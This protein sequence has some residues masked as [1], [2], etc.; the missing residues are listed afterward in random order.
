MGES[1]HNSHH[2]DPTNAR[3]GVLRG[4]WVWLDFSLNRVAALSDPD[5]SFRV[6]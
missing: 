4:I 2:A 5:A 3:H 1:W 6:Q